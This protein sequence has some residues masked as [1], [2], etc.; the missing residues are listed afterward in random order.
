MDKLIDRREEFKDVLWQQ[1]RLLET[2][3]TKRWNESAREFA[4]NDELHYAFVNFSVIDEGRSR[5]C[6]FRFSS[7]EECEKAV[8][9][10]NFALRIVK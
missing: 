5:I 6:I 4:H 7:P 3:M 8:Q 9:A 1:G 10:H 2:K